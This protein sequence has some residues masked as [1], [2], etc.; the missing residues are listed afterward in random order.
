M[1]QKFLLGKLPEFCT[2]L[3]RVAELKGTKQTATCSAA[4]TSSH[5][6]KRKTIDT[7]NTDLKRV[8]GKE[9]KILI[10]HSPESSHF[11]LNVFVVLLWFFL[12]LWKCMLS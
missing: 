8:K 11:I 1:I 2:S 6:V 4:S 10:K 5:P 12:F 9:S 7:E 3:Q